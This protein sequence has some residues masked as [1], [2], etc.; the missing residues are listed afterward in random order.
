MLRSSAL[1]RR[2]PTRGVDWNRLAQRATTDAARA[3]FGRLRQQ[4]D[5]MLKFIT[6]APEKV[7]PIDWDHWRKTIRTPGAV[8]AIKRAFEGLE[9]KNF[10]DQNVAKEATV[11][12][13]QEVQKSESQVAEVKG[14]M[15]E[16]QEE[17]DK[18]NNMKPFEEMSPTEFLD[19]FPADKLRFDME[20]E[21]ELYDTIDQGI[22]EPL[23]GFDLPEE[24][25][26]DSGH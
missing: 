9:V 6:S 12:F 15:S 24:H 2:L 22:W 20:A 26:E 19:M 16:L 1:L 3:D 17:I 13:T 10:D 18:F 11:L 8:D 7:E 14:L 23:K 5:E 21:L 25:E 4:H